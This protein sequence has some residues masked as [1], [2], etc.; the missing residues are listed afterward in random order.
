MP[1]FRYAKLVRD[2]IPGWHRKHGHTVDGRQLHGDEL[3]RALIEKLHEET[4]EVKTALTRSELVE[5]IGDVQQILWDICTTQSISRDELTAAIS[6]KTD[7]KGSYI[8]GEYVES[9]TI[10]SEGDTW[11]QY[12][13]ANPD[14]YPELMMKDR[15]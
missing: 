8:G 2:N 14:K 6:V 7:R 11:T 10:P 5:E 4:D 12:C 9:I 3:L 1:I 15:T 13:R